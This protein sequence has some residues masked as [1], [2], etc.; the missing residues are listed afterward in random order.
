MTKE[1]KDAFYAELAA[2]LEKY[3]VEL[4]ADELYGGGYTAGP[5]AIRVDFDDDWSE[6]FHTFIDSDAKKFGA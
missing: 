2:L 5:S 4:H 1:K 6:E 3:N